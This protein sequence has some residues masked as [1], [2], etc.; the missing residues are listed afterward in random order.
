MKPEEFWVAVYLA[1]IASGD[2]CEEAHDK[3]DCAVE[4]HNNRWIN[5]PWEG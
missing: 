5:E 1:A 2:E 3:A 4:Q